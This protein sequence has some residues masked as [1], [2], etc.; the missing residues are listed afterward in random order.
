MPR[1]V[2]FTANPAQITSGQASTLM[3]EVENATAV[4][5]STVGTVQQTGTQEVR[6]TQTT[7]Y[8]LTATNQSGEISAT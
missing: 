4:T 7:T 5:I 1:I 3:W 2:R 6:P 8:T